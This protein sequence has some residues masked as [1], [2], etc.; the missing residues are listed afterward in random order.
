MYDELNGRVA[1]VT[2]AATGIGRHTAVAF[3]QAGAR[4]TI[5]DVNVEKLKETL[6]M[7]EDAGGTGLL[8][9]TDVSDPK[10]VE[11]M[12]EKTLEEFGQLNY[13]C[14]NAGIGGEMKRTADFS[15]EEWDRLIGINLKGQWLCMKQE[16]LAMLENGGGSIINVAS[17]LGTVGFDQAALYTASKHG[18]VGL[19]K[20][21]A[22]EYAEENIR[23]NAVCPGF[24]DTPM[25]EQAGITS[26]PETR[27]AIEGLHAMGRLGSSDEIADA[28]LWLSSNRSS[29]VTGHTLLVDGGYTAR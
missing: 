18:L 15:V 22:L 2:G 10:Q 29:F 9:R 16:I 7:I 20:A 11:E 23:I 12:I 5:A 14:N 26:D 21:A 28:V 8:T 19:T 25:L 3:A 27:Q 1:L 6:S 13:A 24:I 4:V 17:I